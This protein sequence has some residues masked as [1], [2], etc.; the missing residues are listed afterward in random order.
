MA[1]LILGMVYYLI[2]ATALFKL[3]LLIPKQQKRWYAI[4]HNLECHINGIDDDS[5]VPSSVY[6]APKRG[7]VKFNK[8]NE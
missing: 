5:K 8:N 6:S 3:S 2:R 4:S 7:T 1:L